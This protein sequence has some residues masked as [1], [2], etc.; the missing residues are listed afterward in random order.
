MPREIC[1]E[2][3]QELPARAD[4]YPALIKP[5][6]G[7]GSVGITKD[8]VVRSAAEAE[9]YVAWLRRELPGRALLLQEY[10]PGPEYGV[11]LIGNPGERARGAAGGRGR[12]H[13]AAR[14]AC[15]DPV[16]RIKNAAGLAVLDRDQVQTCRGR[17]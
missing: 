4:L 5:N 17:G 15:P 12:L 14:R 7:D 2:P 13:P 9:R 11:G 10:L 16:P 6:Q 1:L 3:D 8:A